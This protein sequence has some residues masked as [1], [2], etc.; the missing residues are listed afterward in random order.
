MDAGR[1]KGEAL[2]F[3]TGDVAERIIETAVNL[4][5]SST[6]DEMTVSALCAAA[7]VSRQT[8]YNHFR[9][10]MDLAAHIMT[11]TLISHLRSVGRTMT[12]VEAL[13]FSLRDIL[14]T[15]PGMGRSISNSSRR[16]EFH[17]ACAEKLCTALCHELEWRRRV[18]LTATLRFQCATFPYVLS[19]LVACMLSERSLSAN[20]GRSK[21]AG[22][23][24]LGEE[25]V[26]CDQCRSGAQLAA[27][28]VPDDLRQALER[29]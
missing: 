24:I 15:A 21:E 20:P 17:D 9:S 12:L 10:K 11:Y 14:A 13:D 22:D 25:G 18:P 7:H 27:A 23:S 16:S 8:F 19:A 6:F 1:E 5:R 28:Y 3:P 4:S 2:A 29:L 26:S